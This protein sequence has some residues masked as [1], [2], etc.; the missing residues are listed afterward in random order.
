MGVREQVADITPKDVEGVG[1]D[2][3]SHMQGPGCPALRDGCALAV[4]G[5]VAVLIDACDWKF[6][7]TADLRVRVS[8][9]LPFPCPPSWLQCLLLNMPLSVS[10][11]TFSWN[12]GLSM[13][14]AMK[15]LF[16]VVMVLL[17]VFS[18]AVAVG[19]GHDG[20]SLAFPLGCST[21]V[22]VGIVPVRHGRQCLGALDPA[23]Y[24]NINE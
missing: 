21:C 2:G 1:G 19:G 7:W 22:H 17:G 15:L 20:C 16:V 4:N 12:L 10:A 5:H 9:H 14:L 6:A 8:C 18:D 13:S 3:S 23:D 24:I 11:S